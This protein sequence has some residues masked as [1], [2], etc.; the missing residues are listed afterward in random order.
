MLKRL[1]IKDFAIVEELEV[2]FNQGFQ[3]ITGE[4]GAGK[5]ILVG[6]LGYLCGDRASTDILRS[7]AVKTIM[8]A[9]FIVKDSDPI[10]AILESL[11]IE[12]KSNSIIL[13]RE[14]NDKGVSR[15]FVN[16]TPVNLNTL[17]KVSDH[18]HGQHQHQ[19]LLK[20]ETHIDYLDAYGQ[21]GSEIEKYKTTLKEH[22]SAQYQ[23]DELKSQQ[24]DVQEKQELYRFQLIELGNANLIENEYESLQNEK[25]ILENSEMLFDKSTSVADI[26]L[27]SEYAALKQLP[28][29]I[30]ELKSMRGS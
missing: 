18:L 14:I 4:T 29:V 12:N 1:F 25:K 9:E 27:N 30:S 21:L 3:V 15:A 2:I 28:G 23:L 11:E 8:E 5:S 26:L 6:A 10:I 20:Q 19:R 13:R 16:D 7:G 17:N 22:R 24:K